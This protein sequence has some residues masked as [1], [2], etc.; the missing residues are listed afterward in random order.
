[1]KKVLL[2]FCILLLPFSLSLSFNFPSFIWN[3]VS[4]YQTDEQIYWKVNYTQKLIKLIEDYLPFLEKS[5]ISLPITSN[6]EVHF[7][8]V[9]QGDSV[10][11]K[12]PNNVDILI[13]GGNNWYGD[14]V[15]TYL[16][17]Q[18]VDDI[19]YLIATHP[20]ADH[21][22]GLDDVL[23]AFEVENVYAPDVSHTTKT[24]ND[25]V[26]EVRNE[27]T[28][29]KTTKAGMTLIN[30]A[31]AA[32]IGCPSFSIVYFLGPVK[33][34]GTDLNSWSAVMKLDFGNSSY[35]F[36]GDA[37]RISEKDMIDNGMFLKADVLKVGHHGS[38][39]STSKEF[40][41]EVSPKYAVI[42]VGKN[43]NYGHPAQ[44]IL[45]GL[46][47][48]KVDLFRTDLQGHIIAISDGNKI[49]FNVE[50]INTVNLMEDA[51]ES[52]P[53]KTSILIT[54]L[55]VSDEKVTICNNTDEDVDLTG[56]VLVSEVGNQ[57]FNFPDGYVLRVGECVN[58]L[59]GRNA[60]DEPPVNLKWTGVYIW[61]NDSDIAVLYDAEGTLISRLEF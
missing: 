58:I 33:N 31:L 50:P 25:F 39:S 38:Y 34:Y 51:Q 35:L 30:S 13:D 23:K 10:Y 57:K 26:L 2:I 53:Q 46:E 54:N 36:T 60:I 9:G 59:S 32:V 8:D 24:Y 12:L 14:D 20:D 28:Y 1:M 44:E 7:I 16:K 3:Y 41:K 4:S 27:G 61:N 19:E 11:I 43:N 48:Y 47:M 49:N 15:V 5:G 45:E 56:W 52:A 55:D 17:S 21:I 29:I 42:S 37:D 40:L 6:V 18:D 22:G